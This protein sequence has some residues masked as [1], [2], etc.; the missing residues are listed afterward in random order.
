MGEGRRD[1]AGPSALMAT[2]RAIDGGLSGAGNM[3]TVTC[4]D[5]VI[6]Y[7]SAHLL[8]IRSCG[9]AC[10]RPMSLPACADIIGTVPWR[11]WRAR[12]RLKFYIIGT[13]VGPPVSAKFT[14][15]ARHLNLG[16]TPHASIVAV[17][18]ERSERNR[19]REGNFLGILAGNCSASLCHQGIAVDIGLPLSRVW[20][21]LW[22]GR[23]LQLRESYLA[24]LRERWLQLAA[25]RQS[26]FSSYELA[27]RKTNPLLSV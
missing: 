27:P 22:V 10:H 18:R 8:V 23:Y 9:H 2:C 20:V 25:F 19:A 11:E 14:C 12:C 6:R 13:L 24:G 15:R 3:T 17:C 4:G 1:S 16:P 26:R 5:M 21:G 7:F